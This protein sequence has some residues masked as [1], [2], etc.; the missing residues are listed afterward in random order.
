MVRIRGMAPLAANVFEREELRCNAC[1]EV[2]VA[3]PPPGV[4]EEKY[5]ES[6][7]AMIGILHYGAGLPFNRLEAIQASMGIPLAA[8]T[9]WDLV[10][11]TVEKLEPMLEQLTEDAAQSPVIHFDDTTMPVV[12]LMKPETRPQDDTMDENRTGM[13]TTGV[14]AE[15]EPGRHIGLYI[16]GCKHTGENAKTIL[17]ARRPKLGKVIQMCDGLE[18]NIPKGIAT[19]L[20]NCNTHAR[21]KFVEQA[22]NCPE[23]CG[24]VLD[25]FSKVYKHDREAKEQNMDAA[26]RLAHHQRHSAPVMA[27][28]KTWMEHKLKAGEVEPNSGLGKAMAYVLKRWE[29]LTLFLHHPGVPLDNNICERA[30]KKAVMHRKNSLFYRTLNGA[31]VGDVYMSLIHTA[32]LCHVDAFHWI[33]ALLKHHVDVEDNPEAWLP[34]TYLQTLQGKAAAA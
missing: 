28:F 19:Y 15:P 32:Q 23:E 9:Q 30:L 20:V 1:Q 13:F 11:G 26:Q 22:E 6:A 34:W 4:G 21:R 12:S 29:R 31:H 16:T 25:V 18:R 10:E 17:E 5:D 3:P 8:S 27:E 33:T 14:V 24:H 7:C 2:F